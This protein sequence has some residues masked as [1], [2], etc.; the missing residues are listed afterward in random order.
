MPA[1]ARGIG[2]GDVVTCEEHG[3]PGP[4]GGCGLPLD[5]TTDQC[6]SNVIVA[7]TGA[8]RLGDAM[9]AH[10]RNYDTPPC[11]LHTPLCSTGSATVMVNGRPVARMGDEYF[12]VNNHTITTVAQSTVIAG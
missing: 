1:I 9:T 11:D 12:L 8:V 4:D 7:G 6:S 10:P 3:A 2:S 5:W